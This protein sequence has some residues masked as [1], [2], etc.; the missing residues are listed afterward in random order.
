MSADGKE[1]EE[2]LVDYDEQVVDAS[3]DAGEEKEAEVKKC[4]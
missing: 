2:E 4:V 3:A 1:V